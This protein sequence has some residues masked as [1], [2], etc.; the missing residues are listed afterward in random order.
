MRDE[1]G[2]VIFVDKLPPQAIQKFN[3]QIMIS[4]WLLKHNC[5]SV[6]GGHGKRHGKRRSPL[7]QQNI[8]LE[9]L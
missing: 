2:K 3:F 7:G 6:P 1:L 8:K 9:I 4:Q 5:R